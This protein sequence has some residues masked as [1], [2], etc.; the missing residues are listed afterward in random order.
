[1]S[2]LAFVLL[3]ALLWI[4]GLSTAQA[5]LS[6]ATLVD[7]CTSNDTRALDFCQGYVF[8]VVEKFFTT[9]KDVCIPDE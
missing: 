2:R 3:S 6:T 7:A 5:Q 9:G 8:G 4:C 1:M